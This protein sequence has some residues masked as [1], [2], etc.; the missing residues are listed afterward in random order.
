MRYNKLSEHKFKKGKFI[1][2]FNE[3][4]TPVSNNET[5]CFGRL[6]EYI[7][8]GLILNEYGRSKG[9]D[10][11]YHVIIKLNS[12]DSGIVAPRLSEILSMENSKQE[13]FYDYVLTIVEKK[14]LSP[15]TLIFTYSDYPI[16]AKK[17]A[18]PNIKV[19]DRI[20]PLDEV[21]RKSMYH[22]SDF[23][24]DIRFIALYYMCMTGK[25]VMQKEQVENLMKYPYL[26]H[27]DEKMRMLR[28]SIRAS[29][30]MILNM[31][32]KAEWYLISFWRKISIMTE[33]ELYR[34]EFSEETANTELYMEQLHEVFAYLSELLCKVNPLDNKMLVLFGIGTYSYKRLLEVVEHKLF[35]SIS[36][37]GAVRI[38]IEN[39]IMMKYLVSIEDKHE[40]VWA[41]YQFYGIGQYKLIIARFREQEKELKN[42]HVDYKYMECLVNEFIIEE[43]IDMDTKYFDKQNIRSK[44]EFV[45]E[46]ELYGLYYD[47]DSAYEHGLWGAIR[48]SSLLKCDN[49]AH[50]YHCVPDIENNQN[51]KSVWYDCVSIMEKTLLFL[52]SV[53]GIPKYLL[54]EVIKS[55]REFFNE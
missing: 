19:E 1:A 45:G 43:T 53:Y 15:L 48:E 46:K 54:S 31:E 12:I 20:K 8:I 41:E 47:Y 22:Q 2:P 4:V 11:V 55:G 29:E 14:V 37:R 10:K 25:V 35:N 17:F 23:S 32:K 30:L 27:N 50:H 16:F 51:L 18:E 13:E 42:S 3:F 6:P 49:P 52:D 40:N 34:I 39:Y 21:L 28:P 38:L 36:G 44:A 5:W 9:M 26:E 7:W 33:C 24:T